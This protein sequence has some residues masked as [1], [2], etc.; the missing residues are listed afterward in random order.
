MEQYLPRLT[1]ALLV[2]VLIELAK[3]NDAPRKMCGDCR[4]SLYFCGYSIGS[5]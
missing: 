3:V 5:R 1:S 2:A 4:F